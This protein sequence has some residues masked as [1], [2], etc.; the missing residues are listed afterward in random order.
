MFPLYLV[1]EG[2]CT[3]ASKAQFL[4]YALQKGQ[5]WS[6]LGII[7]STVLASVWYSFQDIIE[8]FPDS[9]AYCIINVI[10]FLLLL[11]T[12][13]N[14]DV[15]FFKSSITSLKQQ[16]GYTEE[17]VCECVWKKKTCTILCFVIEIYLFIYAF[18]SFN[19]YMLFTMFS[20]KGLHCT[21]FFIAWPVGH[22]GV[23]WWKH[24]CQNHPMVDVL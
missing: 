15:F 22:L 5:R 12:S 13:F 19:L 3:L 10:T 4:V 23:W 11:G 17:T 24:K 20:F 14:E 21:T 9:L 18:L 2:D 1:N 16:N 7:S 6:F 8:C